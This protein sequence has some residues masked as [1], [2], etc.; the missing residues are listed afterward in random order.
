MA[1]T[2]LQQCLVLQAY[3]LN[4]WDAKEEYTRTIALALLT[5]TPWMSKLP[6]CCFVEE[7][8]EAMLSRLTTR[9]HS[10][11]D[12]MSLFWGTHSTWLAL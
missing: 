3:L 2:V 10:G 8:C 7:A 12:A 9:C 5:W 1:K 4:D 6:G 11:Q